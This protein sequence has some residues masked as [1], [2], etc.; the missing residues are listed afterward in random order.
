[1]YVTLL[2]DVIFVCE[3]GKLFAVIGHKILVCES[4]QVTNYK[5]N[6]QHFNHP[7]VVLTADV[8]QY[9]YKSYTVYI[10]QVYI[11]KSAGAIRTFSH[12]ADNS[13]TINTLKT[14]ECLTYYKMKIEDFMETHLSELCG[15][16]LLYTSPSPRDK[17]QS[18]M[19]SSA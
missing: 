17:R 6:L 19:P 4:Q 15:I 5:H 14:S 13:E 16:C 18:R 7:S 9:F 12:D 8:F 2:V 3:S 11:I 10:L 1:M